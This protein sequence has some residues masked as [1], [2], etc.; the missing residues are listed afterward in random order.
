MAFFKRKSPLIHDEHVDF[1]AI[2]KASEQKVANQVRTVAHPAPSPTP[3]TQS[4]TPAGAQQTETVVIKKGVGGWQYKDVEVPT[5]L[6]V[7]A[8]LFSKT[9]LPYLWPEDETYRRSVDKHE[10]PQVL[11]RNQWTAV[12]LAHPNP[13][14]V[15][16]TLRVFDL[17]GGASSGCA[18]FAQ[19]L[20][21]GEH[22][23][24]QE[25]ARVVWTGNDSVVEGTVDCLG[26]RGATP[27]GILPEDGKRGAVI[28]RDSCPEARRA[29][30]QRL[31]LEAFGPATTG[32]SST[33]GQPVPFK[34]GGLR[35][36]PTGQIE[37][38]EV[39]AAATKLDALRFLETC[40][41]TNEPRQRPPSLFVDRAE[42]MTTQDWQ[43][44]SNLAKVDYRGVHRFIVETPEGTWG[45]DDSGIYKLDPDDRK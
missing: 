27:S 38:L 15:L 20:A 32:F 33:L 28:L 10:N 7:K 29:V 5:C 2:Q 9:P 16:A 35:K 30:F 37:K 6:D 13:D 34:H 19:L 8:L 41:I 40:K 31:A 17:S 12:F 24:A 18:V 1:A 22:S 3:S 23:V 25:A 42:T 26:S 45:K 39:Y 4:A 43:R 14:V 36:I 11:L 44:V 21:H